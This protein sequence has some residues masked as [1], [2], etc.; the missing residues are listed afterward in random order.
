M[1]YRIRT[2]EEGDC[3]SPF[4]MEAD[5]DLPLKIYFKRDAERAAS[6]FITKT[7]VAVPEDDEDKRILGYISL[8]NAEVQIRGIHKIPDKPRANHYEFQPAVRIARLA[9]ADDMQGQGI[10]QDLMS[11]GLTIC[12][13]RI[14]PLVGCRF[15]VV[16]AKQKSMNFYREKFQFE[17]LDT[18]GNRSASA[19]IMWLDLKLYAGA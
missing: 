9:V 11:L 6:S 17:M 2:L 15:A 14:V 19:P 1:D 3:K 8:M 4:L 13:D 16:N 10:G 12:L 7:Y 5:E 18:E